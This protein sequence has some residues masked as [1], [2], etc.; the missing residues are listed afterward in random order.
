M[1]SERRLETGK[2]PERAP[3]E[4]YRFRCIFC[5]YGDLRWVYNPQ[6]M[7]WEARVVGEGGEIGP[8]HTCT[9]SGIWV[10]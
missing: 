7:K 8:T 4:P 6:A 5:G 2:I 9:G 1:G 10:G 3:F